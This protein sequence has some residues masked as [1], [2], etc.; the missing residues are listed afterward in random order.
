[1]VEGVTRV[2]VTAFRGNLASVSMDICKNISLQNSR[3]MLIFSCY[4]N[5]FEITYFGQVLRI[6]CRCATGRA[7]RL[8]KVARGSRRGAKVGECTSPPA[9]P[10]PTRWP[11]GGRVW[12]S[13]AESAFGARAHRLVRAVHYTSPLSYAL[14]LP[15]SLSSLRASHRLSLSAATRRTYPQC[16]DEK[17]RNLRAEILTNARSVIGCFWNSFRHRFFGEIG[18]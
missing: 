15:P 8:E 4:L 17:I 7:S 18:I 2:M 3:L 16:R 12:P 10:P 14:S 11:T 5:N 1:M 6:L 13:L 9:S